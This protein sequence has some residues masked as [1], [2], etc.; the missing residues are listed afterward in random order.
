MRLISSYD[1]SSRLFQ[2]WRTLYRNP[3]II[4][5]AGLLSGFRYQITLL[6]ACLLLGLFLWVHGT[7]PS[8]IRVLAITIAFAAIGRLARGV[9]TSGMLAG[10]GVAFI[11][12]R[13]GFEGF[14]VFSRVFLFDSVGPASGARG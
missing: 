12:P 7:G 14:W 11:I 13:R 2:P 10:G 8:L 5:P 3:A 1:T 6:A 4:Q 9:N